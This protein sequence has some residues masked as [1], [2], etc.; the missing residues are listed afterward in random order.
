MFAP[1][2]A[3]QLSYTA[4]ALT[5]RRLGA[6]GGA[7]AAARASL[8]RRGCDDAL[9]R[10][11][12]NLFAVSSA[13]LLRLKH[14]HG[15]QLSKVRSHHHHNEF[16]PHSNLAATSLTRDQ[17]KLLYTGPSSASSTATGCAMP[18]MKLAALT[19][20]NMTLMILCS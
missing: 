3:I 7:V 11:V 20:A 17:S 8:S 6:L 2:V 14:F 18:I 4:N 5:S 16:T 15:F 12:H 1:I 13:T 10:F 19:A 9:I